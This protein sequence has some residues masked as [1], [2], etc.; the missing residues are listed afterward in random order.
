MKEGEG[1][2]ENFSIEIHR[3]GGD[4]LSYLILLGV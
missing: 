1:L 4:E 3:A 2:G